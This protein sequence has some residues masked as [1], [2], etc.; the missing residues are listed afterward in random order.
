M[1]LACDPWVEDDPNA[2]IVSS[3]LRAKASLTRDSAKGATPVTGHA[4]GVSGA[5][6]AGNTI[7]SDV[8]HVSKKREKYLNIPVY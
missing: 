3:E 7:A 8:A 5:A 4:S 6:S 2:T 1:L